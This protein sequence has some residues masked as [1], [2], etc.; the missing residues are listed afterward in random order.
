M[1]PESPRPQEAS[2]RNTAE[3]L[4][5]ITHPMHH[6]PATLTPSGEPGGQRKLGKTG[7]PGPAAKGRTV[8][9]RKPEKKRPAPASAKK[10]ARRMAGEFRKK[11]GWR[12]EPTV[13]GRKPSAEQKKGAIKKVGPARKTLGMRALE[14]LEKK[15]ARP[16]PA[17]KRASSTRST[18][19]RTPKRTTKRATVRR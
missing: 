12:T 7:P 14:I 19:K 4:P 5:P 1:S 6:L 17:A 11:E 16:A 10:A 15:V 3:L 8:A 2:K 18:A 9:K 13:G